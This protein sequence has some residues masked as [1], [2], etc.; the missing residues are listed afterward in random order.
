MFG[1]GLWDLAPK[2]FAVHP[3]GEPQAVNKLGATAGLDG[4][5]GWAVVGDWSGG[6]VDVVLSGIVLVPPTDLLRAERAK[7]RALHAKEAEKAHLEAEAK[8]QV[9]RDILRKGA[10]HPDDGPEVKLVC[11]T[12]TDVLSI[13]VQAGKH[14]SNELKPY[15][16][17][18]GDEIVIEER[19]KPRH[20][21]KG[22]KVVDYFQKAL[23][24]RMQ[25]KRTK[26]GLLSPDAK[27]VYIE[28]ETKGELLDETV[29][30]APEAYTIQSAEDPAY[31]TAIAPKAVYRKGKPNGFSQPLPFLYMTSLEN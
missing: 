2:A 21:V 25:N 31:A 11:A 6:R 16:A 13:V 29:V 7:L 23:F 5:A 30:D 3:D 8:E 1:F 28:H 24:R 14:T 12:D 26:V 20:D 18:P 4:V 27:W 9:R 15:L 10:K 17:Q 19:D 22:G